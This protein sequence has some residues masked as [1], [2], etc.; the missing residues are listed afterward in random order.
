M[1]YIFKTIDKKEVMTII[2][3][4]DNLNVSKGDT[5]TIGKKLY[6]IISSHLRVPGKT[7]IYA[8]R[9]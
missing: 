1:E 5:I 4:N 8:E 6:V 7:N 2:L 3:K 9:Y